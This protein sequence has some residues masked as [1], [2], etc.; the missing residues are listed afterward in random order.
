MEDYWNTT[1]N[2]P[3]LTQRTH[4]AV[5][6]LL[7]IR[8]MPATRT[9]SVDDEEEEKESNRSTQ[10]TPLDLD[11]QKFLA[12]QIIEGGIEEREEYFAGGVFDDDDFHEEANEEDGTEGPAPLELIMTD[13]DEIA[14]ALEMDNNESLDFD[15]KELEL[16]GTAENQ[17]KRTKKTETK[18]QKLV[19][20]WFETLRL[21]GG[22]ILE[23]LLVKA[24]ADYCDG[25]KEDFAFFNVLGGEKTYGK[26]LILNKCCILCGMKWLCLNGTNKGKPLSP[27]SF[28]KY[29][30]IIFFE[31]KSK[32]GL[33]YD[34]KTDFDEKGQFH[35]V[36]IVSW[37]N[38]RLKDPSFGTRKHNAQFDW[39]ADPKIRKAITDGV[40]KPYENPEHLLLVVLY[41]LGR[42]FLLRGCKEMSTLNHHDTYGGVYGRDMGEL[43]GN[44][45]EAITIAESK[46]NRL[47]LKNSEALTKKDQT[48]ELAE[49]PT[50]VI[51]PVKVIRFYKEHCHPDAVKF[52]AKV[53]TQKNISQWK[54][55]FKKDVWFHP[56]KEGQTQ[57][58]VGHNKIS[59][60]MKTLGGMIGV[61]NLERFTNH[62]LRGYGITKM[63]QARVPLA[64]RMKFARHRC[65]QSQV[66]YARLTK[67]GF[68]EAQLALRG[69][70]STSDKIS[71]TVNAQLKESNKRKKQQVDEVQVLKVSKKVEVEDVEEE[72]EGSLVTE[73]ISSKGSKLDDMS[74]SELLAFIKSQGRFHPTKL[75]ETPVPQ[76][77]TMAPIAMAPLMH[78]PPQM[79]PQVQGYPAMMVPNQQ[80]WNTPMAINTPMSIN[81]GFPTYQQPPMQ[82][83]LQMYHGGQQQ[84]MTQPFQP[85]QQ[86]YQPGM[87]MGGV[88]PQMY[89]TPGPHLE[90]SRQQIQQQSTL[91]SMLGQQ[92]GTTGSFGGMYGSI[93]PNGSFG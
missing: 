49:N 74:R 21:H 1:N 76:V 53:G 17:G 60:F 24:P 37:H 8:M 72:E 75:E 44:E 73:S 93:G 48:I 3:P 18:I 7:G 6:G 41:V 19:E 64:M 81:H 58:N 14:K 78:Q 40:L 5:N 70:D 30:G 51:C 16:L 62:A 12:A 87:M 13:A 66:P 80:F 4:D 33:K 28:T 71:A 82:S 35:S 23:N 46:T 32:R 84:M 11:L 27:K 63:H 36:M 22:T 31:F 68:I 29:M 91:Y 50:D 47:S 90:V 69:V 39:E 57:C 34:F 55:Q 85:Q 67:D 10:L 2:H 9:P 45:Y 43:G 83:A 56:A 77:V 88:Q 15:D 59:S 52:F 79:V 20:R 86:M 65:E 89:Q 42:M 26:T 92:N 61:D 25:R 54:H 38:I